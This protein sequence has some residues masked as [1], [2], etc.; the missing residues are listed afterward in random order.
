[1]EKKCLFSKRGALEYLFK[2]YKYAVDNLTQA[3]KLDQTC[4]LAFFNRAL[5]YQQLKQFNNA[6]K[7][8]GVVLML[9]SYLEFKTYINRGLLY[10]SIKD[11][12]NALNDFRLA[13]QF[14]QENYHVK[15]MIGV[16]L[17]RLNIYCALF[18]S[19]QQK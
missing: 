6:L 5:C 19:Q 18:C 7:D 10:F 4:S 12:Q 2:S 1:M 17:H 3:I 16:C 13:S 8:F 9:G 14:E 15:H 11:Y